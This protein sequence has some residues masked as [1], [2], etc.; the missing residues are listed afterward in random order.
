MGKTHMWHR[1]SML[2]LIS[3]KCGLKVK[4]TQFT[5]EPSK[6]TCKACLKKMEQRP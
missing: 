1:M 2:G 5:N 4:A 6:V 3:V